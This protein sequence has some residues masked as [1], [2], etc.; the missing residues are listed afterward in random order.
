MELLPGVE[1]GDIGAKLGFNGKD[2]GYL[3]FDNYR[4]PRENM[5]TRFSKLNEKGE[6]KFEGNPR[7]VYGGMYKTRVALVKE[8]GF[9]LSIGVT[10]ATR[11]STVRT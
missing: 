1:A 7:I 8:T 6:F 5:L 4:I 10:I 11:Y 9:N 2:N 3:A